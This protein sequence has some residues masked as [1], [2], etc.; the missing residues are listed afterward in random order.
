MLS[1]QKP[2]APSQPAQLSAVPFNPDLPPPFVIRGPGG[3]V[4]VRFDEQA[5]P[6]LS[7]PNEAVSVDSGEE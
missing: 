7:S 6:H 3:V 2:R 5:V 4:G 1:R